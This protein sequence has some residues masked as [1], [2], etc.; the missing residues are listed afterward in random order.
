MSDGPDSP[1]EPA[2]ATVPDRIVYLATTSGLG[3]AE[4][5]VRALAQQFKRRGADVG[6]ISMLP[7]EPLFADLEADGIR[8]VSLGMRQGFPDPRGLVRLARVLQRWRPQVL[9]SHM[10]HANLLARI[11]RILVRVPVVVSTIHNEDE[12]AQWRY[13]AY[14]LTDRL[15]DATTAV[16]RAAVLASIRRGAQGPRGIRFVPNGID[17]HQPPP[18][19]ETVAALRASLGVDAQFVWLAVG[20]L[21]EAK[22]YPNLFRAFEIVASSRPEACLL[23]AGEGPLEN[24]L[25]AMVAERGL[26]DRVLML[27][28]RDDV[29]VLMALADAFVLAS[30]WEGLPMVLLEA[31]AMAM[32]IVATDVGGT[33]DVVLEEV[34]GFV[35]RRD[36]PA[37]LA[38]EMLRMMAMKRELRSA[39]G[40][41]GRAHVERHFALA[42]VA[43]EWAALYRELLLA[44]GRR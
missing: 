22:D 37:A 31:A 42:T 20:R 9:H 25:R 28:R 1:G 11:A 19:P 23:V 15:A 38:D 2:A 3:G 39:M 30:A 27:G 35:V 21:S 24:E 44:R 33:R 14:R 32:P 18:D 29:P 40:V 10:V 16:S 8:V 5:Q 43:D 36:D 41:A 17:M 6:V 4:Q 26:A 13:A 12:G 7:L 34:S